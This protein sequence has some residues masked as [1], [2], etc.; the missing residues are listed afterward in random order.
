MTLYSKVERK[1]WKDAKFRALSKPEPNAQSLFLRLLTA[2]ESTPVPGLIP[3]RAPALADEL[4]WPLERF[5]K[6]F[7]ELST[8]GMA[9]ADWDAGLVF[10]PNAIKHN[11]PAN[12]NIV[13]GWLKH[14]EEM[15]ECEL[16]TC[17]ISHISWEL[18]VSSG[19]NGK[20]LPEL[21]AKPSHKP[22]IKQ[23]GHGLATQE[24]EQEQEQE[25]PPKPP[26]GEPVDSGAPEPEQ[27]PKTSEPVANPEPLKLAPEPE[28][29][30][31]PKK[32]RKREA[33][34][35]TPEERELF[36]LWLGEM[37]KRKQPRRELGKT[38]LAAIRTA[39][40]HR[41]QAECRSAIRGAFM[42]KWNIDKRKAY[43]IEWVIRP[44]NIDEH[45]AWDPK[46]NA[47][48]EPPR[49][50]GDDPRCV[51]PADGISARTAA[52]E[53]RGRL[54]VAEQKRKRMEAQNAKAI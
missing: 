22:S 38:H 34:E 12:R 21:F 33:A 54:A 23:L 19:D 40:E 44:A 17:A 26:Q 41:S 3:V 32:V 7:A 9:Y 52:A 48:D 43:D 31:K 47:P 53:E 25:I 15:P 10:L 29:V 35:A 24:Q 11:Q 30:A 42:K 2:P 51:Q 45:M 4:G 6:R 1:M 20:P 49:R 39:R 28:P 46:V 8:N 14:V 16:L 36:D 27:E 18:T 50:R 5:H 37:I 13:K